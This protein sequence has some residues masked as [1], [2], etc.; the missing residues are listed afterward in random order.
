M[1][2]R[3]VPATVSQGTTSTKQTAS[4]Q[5]WVPYFGTLESTCPVKPQAYNLEMPQM[6]PKPSQSNYTY[7]CCQG[8][9]KHMG[10]TPIAPPSIP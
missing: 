9:P 8:T 4:G 6:P 10:V 2:L 5:E 3:Q 1:A 7:D